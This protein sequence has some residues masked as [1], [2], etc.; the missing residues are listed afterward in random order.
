MFFGFIIG[1]VTTRRP[2][3]PFAM[4]SL[5]IAEM[6]WLAHLCLPRFWREAGIDANRTRE[7][8]CLVLVTD[9]KPSLLFSYGLVP[10]QYRGHVCHYQNAFGENGERREG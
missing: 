6:V 3:T 2:G 1:I 8:R 7:G 5:G 4:I 10:N 9:L